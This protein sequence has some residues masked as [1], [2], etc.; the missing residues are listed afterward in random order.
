M[1]AYTAGKAPGAGLSAFT[2]PGEVLSLWLW[3]FH[4]EVGP[5]VSNAGGKLCTLCRVVNWVELLLVWFSISFWSSAYG[6]ISQ[7]PSSG[8]DPGICSRTLVH[9]WSLPWT[10]QA[11]VLSLCLGSLISLAQNIFVY[12]FQST[13]G[14]CAGIDVVLSVPASDGLRISVV[15]RTD[16]SHIHTLTC[17]YT[18]MRDF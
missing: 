12:S 4:C 11:P 17:V 3:F 10:L 1:G 18:H 16:G 5:C 15:I 6:D 2:Q 8:S 14:L 9:I 13:H 7:S